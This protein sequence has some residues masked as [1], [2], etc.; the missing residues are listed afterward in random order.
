MKVED[1]LNEFTKMA[2]QLNHWANES[3]DGGWSTHQVK[4][5]QKKA[6]ELYQLIDRLSEK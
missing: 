2:K 1:V 5:M 6:I 3:L 4:P